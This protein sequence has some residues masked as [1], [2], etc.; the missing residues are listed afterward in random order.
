[1]SVRDVA[2]LRALAGWADDTFVA[3][4]A[5]ADQ[6]L[7]WAAAEFGRRLAVSCSMVDG[8]V[9]HL[10]SRH[11]PGVDVLFIDTGYHFPETIGTRDQVAWDLDVRVV[12]VEPTRS[13]ERQDAFLGPRLHDRDP[14]TC[15][16]LR[17]IEPLRRALSGY[18]AWV[19]GVRRGETPQR[20]GTPFVSW[21]ERNRVVKIA[22]IAAWTEDDVLDYVDRHRVPVNPLLAAG[23]PS[24]GCA[25]CTHPVAAGADPRSGRW[26]GLAKTECGLHA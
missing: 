1:M 20:A 17:K 14:A 7:T 6:I 18:D 16:R 15:C 26:A 8:V 4:R 12:H 10:V 13:V 24:I 25:P 23:Y 5:D 2:E 11:A 22:P 3:A 21:D 19:T 9:P